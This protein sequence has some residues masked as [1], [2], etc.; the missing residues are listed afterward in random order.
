MIISYVSDCAL[1]TRITNAASIPWSSSKHVVSPIHPSVNDPTAIRR[2][3]L[4]NE[5]PTFLCMS[6]LWSTSAV[7]VFHWNTFITCYRRSTEPIENKR[8]EACLAPRLSS[9]LWDEIKWHPLDPD[10]QQIRSAGCGGG[11]QSCVPYRCSASAA[12]ECFQ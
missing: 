6:I 3:V 9:T 2:F 12:V 1:I 7:F 11:R 8:T 4:W 5:W 10:T